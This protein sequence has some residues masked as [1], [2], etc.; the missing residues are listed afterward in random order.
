MRDAEA[1]GRVLPREDSGDFWDRVVGYS[2]WF[3]AGF[4]AA[5]LLLDWLK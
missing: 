2:F 1:V 4:V 3:A 5:I